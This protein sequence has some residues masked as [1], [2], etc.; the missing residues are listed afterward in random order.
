MTFIKKS[1]CCFS[2]GVI[3]GDDECS[4]CLQTLNSQKIKVLPCEHTFH[5][6][7]ILEWLTNTNTCPICRK[8]IHKHKMKVFFVFV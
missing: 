1:I 5:T 6:D 2:I 4:I 3:E 8:S 7:C